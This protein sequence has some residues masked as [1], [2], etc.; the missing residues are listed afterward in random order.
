MQRQ[1]ER[2]RSY[3]DPST[4]EMLIADFDLSNY[5]NWVKSRPVAD[6]LLLANFLHE[7][8]HRWCFDSRVGA[9]LAFLRL[10][11][12]S[13]LLTNDSAF[14]DYVRAMTA[15]F[16]LEPIAEGLSLFA[17]FDAYPG[18]SNFLSQTLTASTLFF[19]PAIDTDGKPEILLEG[20]LQQL[21][22][23]PNLLERK[24]AIYAKK[25]L[26]PYAIGYLSIKSLWKQMAGAYKGFADRDL[27]LSYVR[28]Y[29]YEDP[30]L[31]F[32]LLKPA[33][34][35][36]HAA[37]NISNYILDRFANLLSF[38]DLEKKV[39]LWVD[40][41]KQGKIDVTSIN[42]NSDINNKA[43]F[44]FDKAIVEDFTK[45][46]EYENLAMWIYMLIE[47]RALCI[48]GIIDV[49]LEVDVDQNVQ[50]INKATAENIYT[51]ILPALAKYNEGK[52]YIIAGRK[53]CGL[54]SIIGI[55]QQAFL[56]SSLGEFEERDLEL[57][58]RIVA[59]KKISE[60]LFK[61]ISKKLESDGFVNKV[62]EIVSKRVITVQEYLYG[63][64]C[65]LNAQEED[66]S[67][68]FNQIKELG[69]HGMLGYDGELTRAV[70]GIGLLNSFTLNVETIKA[71]AP[72]LDI[73]A[74]VLLQAF[75]TNQ[76]HGLPIIAKINDSVLA[77][78]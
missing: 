70:A 27:F 21:R 25:G 57:A 73:D 54:M 52:L 12:G 32:E 41:A 46:G 48:L 34:S 30:G 23:N 2:L 45:G 9:T 49:R 77:L 1:N 38:E 20:L 6:N 58:K 16:L 5:L 59:N 35:E 72:V 7:W 31:V 78:V 11:A 50:I 33:P 22:R 4:N 29:I 53:A 67:Q 18:K 76:V 63:R 69:L 65:T 43:G 17:E 36:M 60:N 56:V 40:T 51:T 37:E 55:N 10:R 8:T 3:V 26:D 62:W 68:A 66:W 75:Q 64:L 61:D 47:E 28:S 74:D 24:A 15:M 42:S 13:R 71:F 39:L 19:S 44:M 14:D